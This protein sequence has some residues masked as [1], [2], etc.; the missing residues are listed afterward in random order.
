[1][2]GMHDVEYVRRLCELEFE[3][4]RG[5]IWRH[6]LHR[7]PRRILDTPTIGVD[8]DIEVAELQDISLG[9]RK[10]E[11]DQPGSVRA[12]LDLLNELCSASFLRTAEPLNDEVLKLIAGVRV[13]ADIH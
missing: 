1:M 4:F 3:Q 6:N 13:L 11:R 8:A 9:H 10:D 5:G 12:V 2:V 7:R